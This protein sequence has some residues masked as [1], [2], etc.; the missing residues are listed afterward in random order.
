MI[1]IRSAQIKVFEDEALKRFEEEMMLHSKK[2]SPLLCEI[3]GDEQLGVAISQALSRADS[4]GFTNRGPIRLYIEMMFLFGS[5]F[6]TDPQY[7]EV[8]EL[9]NA[10]EDQM[11]R[12]EK[13]YQGV[14]DYQEKVSGQSNINVREALEALLIFAKMPVLVNVNNFEI[15]MLQELIRAFPQ[16]VTYVGEEGMITLIREGRAEAQKYGF[17]AV[18]G[19]AMMVILM[20][21]FGHGCTEDPLYPWMARTLK[22][23]RIKDSAAR[24]KRLEKKAVT[25]LDYVLARPR[26]RVST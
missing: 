10:S 3:L 23:E 8:A 6:D 5:D 13:L 25:W 22:D 16:K 1:K 7:P 26:A 24:A 21:A 20:F 14:L 18:R 4:Y 19:E 11:Q 15:E 2:Y 12:A 17:P 9:L